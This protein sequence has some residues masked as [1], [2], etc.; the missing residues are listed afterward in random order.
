MSSADDPAKRFT[1]AG[2]RITQLGRQQLYVE[3]SLFHARG[4]GRTPS[5]GVV[6]L[7]LDPDDTTR[8]TTGRVHLRV[9]VRLNAGIPSKCPFHSPVVHDPRNAVG[10]DLA[11]MWSD[12]LQVMNAYWG[13]EYDPLLSPPPAPRL[14][15]PIDRAIVI[16]GQSLN[17]DGTAPPTLASRVNAAV[18]VWKERPDRTVL[19]PTGGDPVRAGV[20]EAEIMRD[21]LLQSGAGIPEDRIVLEPEALKY[22]GSS[23]S[24]ESLLVEQSERQRQRQ[25]LA[26]ILADSD[27]RDRDRVMLV[28]CQTTH[29]A[30]PLSCR[31]PHHTCPPARA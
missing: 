22:V 12:C 4:A 24:G 20:S 18:A 1:F 9:R 28:H 21:L 11:C 15:L 2:A 3:P 19:I 10:D 6:S 25:R 26:E 31:I 16:L 30:Y 13:A 14:P 8:G 17:P 29:H 27:R 7:W 5:G 23:R